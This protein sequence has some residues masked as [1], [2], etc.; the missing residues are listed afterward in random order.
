VLEWEQGRI[1]ITHHADLICEPTYYRFETTPAGNVRLGTPA[2]VG[3]YDDLVTA[4]ALAAMAGNKRR[5]FGVGAVKEKGR[6]VVGE[7]STL[8]ELLGYDE[9]FYFPNG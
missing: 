8:A 7:P 2:G 3:H 6:V 5:E 9:P 1:R 4:L